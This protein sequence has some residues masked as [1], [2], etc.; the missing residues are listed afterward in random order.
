MTRPPRESDIQRR[1]LLLL[2]GLL[3]TLT[4]RTAATACYLPDGRGGYRLHRPLPAGWPDVT[5]IHHGRAVA[6]EV[7][8]P[9]AGLRPTQVVMQRAW[10]AA[11]GVWLTVTDPS[12]VTAALAAGGVCERCGCWKP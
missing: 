12:Q 1:V 6:V 10:E 11:G 9:G 2:G 8:R 4:A 7:K 5:V 3:H